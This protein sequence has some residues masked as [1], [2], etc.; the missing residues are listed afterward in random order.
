[1]AG[2]YLRPLSDTR[3]MRNTVIFLFSSFLF[4]SCAKEQ[5]V[6]NIYSHRHYEADRAL[7]DLFEK[8]TGIKIK[9]VDAS[10]D[11]IITRLEAEGAASPADLIITVDAGRIH[12]AAERGLLAAA[13]PSAAMK[14]IPE[15]L[16]SSDYS[17][18]GITV[19]ARVIAYSKER[20]NPDTIG[21]YA[22]LADPKFK[23]RVLS[24]K[25]DN[26]YNQSLVAAL[27]ATEGEDATGEWIK[28]MVDNFARE[29]KGNDRDQIRDIAS[30]AGDLALV[31]TYYMGLMA[32]SDEQADR[33][34]FSKVGIIFPNQNG[35]GTH[36]NVSAIG[37]CKHSPNAENARKFVDFMLSKSAQQLLTEMNYEYPVMP[38]G[39]TLPAVMTSWGDFKKDDLAME[40]IGAYVDRA[41]ELM[42]NNGWK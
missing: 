31:N 2:L 7:Y 23:G 9:V 25:S 1:M 30:G 22:D 37:F 8:E 3:H 42:I 17:W 33:D 34:A 6:L 24:R 28:A 35:R 16:R 10:A 19:R 41:V 32:N 27:T 29:P 12:R 40:K 20:I 5:E 15:H 11:E 38:E 26:I 13:E 18:V 21:Q 4:F 14:A 39:V 36:I